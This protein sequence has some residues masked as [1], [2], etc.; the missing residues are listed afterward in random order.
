MYLKSNFVLLIQPTKLKT[1]NRNRI[2]PQSNRKPKKNVVI[3]LKNVKLFI[4]KTIIILFMCEYDVWVHIPCASGNNN[5]I[6]NDD[7]DDR[8]VN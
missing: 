4:G 1:S 6:H 7:G 8:E 2:K 3:I 5:I